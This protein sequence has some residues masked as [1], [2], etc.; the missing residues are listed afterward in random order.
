MI[1]L[2]LFIFSIV[3]IAVLLKFI[4]NYNKKIYM[5]GTVTV[6]CLILSILIY[7]MPDYFKYNK[8]EI[9]INIYKRGVSNF[10]LI[11]LVFLLKIN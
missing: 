2:G 8:S 7:E 9:D 10:T 1:L 3:F 5:F 6:L 4:K 11:S